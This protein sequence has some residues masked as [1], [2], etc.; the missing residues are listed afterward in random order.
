M[1]RVERSLLQG[2]SEALLEREVSFSQEVP[3]QFVIRD[4]VEIRFA[5]AVTVAKKPSTHAGA[6]VLLFWDAAEAWIAA[7]RAC[8]SPHPLATLIFPV[9]NAQGMLEITLPNGGGPY[10]E[11]PD[12]YGWGCK[13]VED[14]LAVLKAAKHLL[15]SPQKIL[16]FFNKN[17]DGFGA[18]AIRVDYVVSA[19]LYLNGLVAELRVYLE[20]RV[21]AIESLGFDEDDEPFLKFA[22]DVEVYLGKR[23]GLH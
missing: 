6:H 16:D 12:F 21:K 8:P 2:I 17:P 11:E 14:A 18:Y 19:L 7:L 5:F 20:K 23:E 3:G 1:N 13:I 9:Q 15:D 4:A 10:P 22:R